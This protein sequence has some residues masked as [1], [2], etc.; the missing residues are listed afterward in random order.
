[1]S[2]ERC[3]CGCGR[4][5]VQL[6]H[7]CYRQSLRH[8]DRPFSQLVKDKRNLVPCSK[9]CH[10]RHHNRTRPYELS[11]LPDSVFEFAREVMGAGPA[12]VYLS[13]HYRG[14]DDR[15]DMLVSNESEAA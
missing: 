12:F 13:R 1:M 15:L 2:T 8:L 10:E 7:V 11:M 14:G 5:A 6:H 4:R 3:F 9:K